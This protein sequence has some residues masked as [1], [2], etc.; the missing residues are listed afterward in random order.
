MRLEQV[1]GN[2]WALFSWE[3]IPLYKLDDRRCILLDTGL[4]DQREKLDTA[5]QE[6]DLIP[7][8]II[9]THSHIDHM[10]NNA[11]LMEKYGAKLAMPLFEAGH[12]TSY[13]AMNSTNY[14]LSPEDVEAA[15]TIHGTPCLA[16]RIILPTE[17]S[18]SFCGA[19]F[20]ILHT[21][22]HTAG[23]I[24]VRTPDDVLYLADA[25]MTGKTL[26]HS[27]FPYAYSVQ[28]Y[29]DSMRKIR[30]EKAAKYVVA[31]FGI[32]DEILPL[33]D[34]EARFLAERMLELLNLI[35]GVTTPKKL[36]SD[37]CRTYRINADNLRD[38]AYF[39]ASAQA[40]LNYLRV[41]GHVEA[42][43]EDNQ[44]LFRRT[45]Y[46]WEWERKKETVTLPQPGQ[47]R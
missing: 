11:F 18:I 2:T 35:P 8:G 28:H 20:G 1:K 3:I 44:I 38:L 5:L 33:I 7:V 43:M 31:H 9:C 40:Y 45:A 26:H 4:V 22:G 19:E 21:P 37:I 25:M 46:S 39:E 42:F 36:A 15:P 24:C 6:A 32:Y 47:F 14:L 17:E 16:D 29:L 10:G 12:Q 30:T 34:M 13:L 27:K 23:H 41:L